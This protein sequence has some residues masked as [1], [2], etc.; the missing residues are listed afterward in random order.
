MDS[1]LVLPKN[2]DEL[3]LIT[4]LLERM[5]IKTKVLT[6][7]QKEDL[8]LIHLMKQADRTDKVSRSEV[9]AKLGKK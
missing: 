2:N 6:D 7:E 8:G 9:M 5:K 4:S 1:L 3:T